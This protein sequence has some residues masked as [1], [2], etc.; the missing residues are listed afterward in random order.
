M[1]NLQF[2]GMS[3]IQST[4]GMSCISTLKLSHIWTT[5]AAWEPKRPVHLP[6]HWFTLLQSFKYSTSNG[7]NSESVHTK[8]PNKPDFWSLNDGIWIINACS[9]IGFRGIGEWQASPIFQYSSAKTVASLRL[10]RT[11]RWNIFN[12]S[13]LLCR[14]IIPIQDLLILTLLPWKQLTI[15]CSLNTYS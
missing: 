13:K 3:T 11:L 8:S 12:G 9:S 5:A 1:I 14:E 15:G 4:A 10:P 2:H 6:S 7:R